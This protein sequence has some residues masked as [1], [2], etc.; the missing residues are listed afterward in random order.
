MW[1]GIFRYSSLGFSGCG[2][3]LR[4]D[5]SGFCLLSV[6]INRDGHLFPLLLKVLCYSNQRSG[7]PDGFGFVVFIFRQ[8]Q[9]ILN[10][11]FL[12]IGYEKNKGLKEIGNRSRFCGKFEIYK[13]LNLRCFLRQESAKLFSFE[14]FT[15][16][17]KQ[18]QLFTQFIIAAK[19]IK[20]SK[21]NVGL[22]V[23]DIPDNRIGFFKPKLLKSLA[24]MM[25]VDYLEKAFFLRARS[26]Y[27]RLIPSAAFDIA[28]EFIE[29]R[30]A[31][32]VGIIGV[33]NKLF[34]LD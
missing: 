28:N 22:L 24:A 31:L 29:I 8:Q 32:F 5:E 27:Q 26:N 1:Y 11:L 16:S 25:A 3:A 33:R 20:R 15:Q 12:R 4:L 14:I 21:Q 23:V 7:V 19:P 9:S 10:N 30:F 13:V 34:Q 2:E 18:H 17:F 6:F